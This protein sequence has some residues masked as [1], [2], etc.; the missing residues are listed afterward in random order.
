M[1]SII[2]FFLLVLVSGPVLGQEWYCYNEF[3]SG[4]TQAGCVVNT[5]DDFTPADVRFN[6]HGNMEICMYSG[7]WAGGG[8]I[9]ST[10][11]YLVIITHNLVW[12]SPTRR[13]RREALISL[14]RSSNIAVVQVAGFHEP[15]I[16]RE[17]AGKPGK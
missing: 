9:L 15:M 10:S 2:R 13:E 5:D 7:C 14:E 11:P 17:S 12:N 1:K 6:A 4:C 16:C 8:V 3:E